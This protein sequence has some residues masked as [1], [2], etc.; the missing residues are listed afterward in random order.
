MGSGRLSRRSLLL[1]TLATKLLAQ[2]GRGA[3]FPAVSKRYADPTTELEVF[4]LTDPGYSSRL[5]ASYNRALARN[6]GS[7]FFTSDRTGS[8]QAFRMDLKSAQSRQL[9]ETEE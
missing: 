8:P 3:A 1:S 6:S 7:L 4:L 2:A 9:T 5:P